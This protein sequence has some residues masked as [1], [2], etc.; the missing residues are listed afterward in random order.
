MLSLDL[1]IVLAFFLIIFIIGI[2]DRK[3]LTIE[4][5]WVNSRKTGLFALIATI[6][7]SFIGAGSILGGAGFTYQGSRF[8]STCS[9]CFFLS[10]YDYLLKI[11]CTK[12]KGIWR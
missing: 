5:Y 12:N 7:S 1:I 8:C 11:L 6:T 4:D 3:K 10:I 2:I 9:S